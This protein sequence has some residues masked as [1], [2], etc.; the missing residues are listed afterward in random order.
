MKH[1]PDDIKRKLDAFLR[2]YYALKLLKGLIL[3]LGL[4]GL[5]FLLVS[6]LEYLLHMGQTARMVLFYSFWG[7]GV[8]VFVV[9]VAWPVLQ[10][11][12]LGKTMN[13]QE[14]SK[15]I[16]AYFPE[17][18][19]KLLNL[20]QLERGAS[21]NA[22]ILASI[23][24]RSRQLSP[25]NFSQALDLG[26][27]LRFWPL[28]ALPV[29]IVL[30]LS[31]SGK[32]SQLGE[33]STRVLRYGED[34]KPAFPFRIHFLSALESERGTNHT[35]AVQF[36][37]EA[38]PKEMLMESNGKTIRL[39]N[40]GQGRFEHVFSQLTRDQQMHFLYSG[41]SSGQYTL[42]VKDVP[43]LK[44]FIVEV[45]PPSYTG[46][47]SK[48]QPVENVLQVPEGSDMRFVAK[49]AFTERLH[50]QFSEDSA[51]LFEQDTQ[52]KTLVFSL[53]KL[54]S[55]VN[56]FIKG[57][58]EAGTKNLSPQN[59]VEIQKDDFPGISAEWQRDSVDLNLLY[60]RFEAED[61]YGINQVFLI[62]EQE[63]KILYREKMAT[64]GSQRAKG[65]YGLLNL[66]N[67]VNQT[68][69]AE[70]YLRVYDNDGVNGSKSTRSNG[71]E[72]QLL[73]KQDYQLF[74]KAQLSEAGAERSKLNERFKK[75]DARLSEQLKKIKKG[76]YDWKEKKELDELL[77]EQEKLLE[78]KKELEE[79]QEELRKQKQEELPEDIRDKQKEEELQKLVDEIQK[80][81]DKLGIE[82]LQ[83]K[84][85]KL[86]ELTEQTSR[87]EQRQQELEKQLESERAIL[88]TIDKLQELSKKEE[89]LS[90]E[91]AGT[92]EERAAKKAAQKELQE[93]FEEAKQEV[94]K[95]MEENQRFGDAAEKE[96]VEQKKEQAAQDMQKAGDSKD[97]GKQQKA[98]QKASE[99]LQEM[100]KGLQDAFMAM[101]AQ[102]DAEDAEMLR[103][104]L[105]NVEKLS[106]GSE[107]VLSRTQQIQKDDPLVRKLLLEQNRLVTGTKVIKDSLTAL[108][109]RNP[110]I[111][112]KVFE[113]LASIE[114][115]QEKSL[116][117]MQNVKLAAS[118]GHQQY[119]MLAANNL[120]L[121]LDASLQNMMQQMANK[122]PGQQNCQKPGG[123][124]PNKAGLA[125]M[126]G[127]LAKQMQQRMK[128]KQ[129]GKDGKNGE[130]GEQGDPG[131]LARII[132]QQE[133]LR[134]AYQQQKEGKEGKGAGDELTDK[135]LEEVEKD[136]YND[137]ITQETLERVKEIES[138]LL[139]DER[140]ERKQEMD[141]QRQ[142]ETGTKLD[143]EKTRTLEFLKRK[144]K[145]REAL[146]YEE[147]MLNNQYKT[148]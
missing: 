37:G 137:N 69:F 59:S 89:K 32:V 80:L 85:E 84:L 24:Q 129:K 11:L 96:Q 23:D 48:V 29:V 117:E 123:S 21:E 57:E 109:N 79:K 28:L 45:V 144:A 145:T 94:E 135:L 15:L 110:K 112:Q 50:F 41:L 73:D 51:G 34:F 126:Q 81:K 65:G 2:R 25:F 40:R 115:N 86:K 43:Q 104:I 62:V 148:K 141:E 8:S 120:A 92:E 55:A 106:F 64:E 74:L 103:R 93:Q 33:A 26:R 76:E 7:L 49:A 19:D 114:R 20:I 134:Q 119:V 100:A 63:G 5:Y 44:D 78:K 6:G 83:K 139:E 30:L 127:E 118:A 128:G 13:Y 56:Y 66:G 75:Q 72:T 88:E 82:E 61:D 22:L 36:E 17:I 60:Y 16:G 4:T 27:A 35:L 131:E 142:A 111:K 107:A 101:Q 70:V 71:Y 124:K 133:Q 116:T 53:N 102:S 121:M 9:Y 12:R 3:G 77:K 125:K 143:Q 58:A 68:A 97:S 146:L 91:E 38:I 147:L 67:K 130:E 10:L 46:L 108:A 113:E 99:S 42:E 39:V 31:L 105:E 122:K 18:D 98:Q 54:Q 87:Q 52:T 14:A 1:I 136:L 47:K 90:K 95:Q 140:A 132:S 138:R